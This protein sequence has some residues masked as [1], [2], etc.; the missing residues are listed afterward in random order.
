MK[1]I[2]PLEF[3]FQQHISVIDNS[4]NEINFINT[5]MATLP[6][7]LKRLITQYQNQLDEII[8]K[9]A[10]RA[11]KIYNQLMSEYGT[12]NFKITLAE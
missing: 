10:P 6:K 3:T 12:T 9:G 5:P 11:T 7:N 2:I 4:G 1:I 8:I